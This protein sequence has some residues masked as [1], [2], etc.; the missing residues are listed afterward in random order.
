MR[1]AIIGLTAGLACCAVPEGAAHADDR[2]TIIAS[3][4]NTLKLPGGGC[5]CI[6]DKATSEFKDQEFAFF[7]AVITDDKAA[8]AEL[9]GAMTVEQLTHVAMRMTKMPAECAGG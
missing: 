1:A 7:M 5:D 4:G 2:D 3:C 9:R 6:A 8:Q